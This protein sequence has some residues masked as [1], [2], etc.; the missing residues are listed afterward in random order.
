MMK[1]TVLAVFVMVA[2][3]FAVVDPSARPAAAPP[4]KKFRVLLPF[5]VGITFFPISVA[6]SSGT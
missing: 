2:V 1:R 3:A 5:R 6:T 4:L